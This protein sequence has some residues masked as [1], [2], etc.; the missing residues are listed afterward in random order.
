MV[1]GLVGISLVF[2]SVW[3][4]VWVMIGEWWLLLQ[5]LVFLISFL[6]IS[7]FSLVLL[8]SRVCR[9]FC[10][11]SNFFCLLWIFIFFRCVNWCRWVLRMQLVCIL[12]SLKCFISIVLGWFLVWMMWIILLR[13]RKVISKLFSRCRWCLILFRWNCRC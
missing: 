6:C 4:L 8:L 2:D 3:V 10:F 1:I 9:C 11:F 5:V 12:L 13:L 7:F